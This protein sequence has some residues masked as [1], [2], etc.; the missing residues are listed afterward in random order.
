MPLILLAGD[1]TGSA[2]IFTPRPPHANSPTTDLDDTSAD[3]VRAAKEPLYDLTFEVECGATVGSA[4]TSPASDGSDAVD[5]F[6][7]SYELNQVHAL[8]LSA[9]AE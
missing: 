7:P 3:G 6:L 8:R 1:C 4:A 5:I 2:Y 9:K